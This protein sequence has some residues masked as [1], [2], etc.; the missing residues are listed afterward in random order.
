MSS[1]ITNKKAIVD[2]LWEW[3]A[4]QGDWSKLL[5]SKIVTTESPFQLLTEMRY[6]ITFYNPLIFTP[7]YP[8]L[9]LQS[10]VTHRLQNKYN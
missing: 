5:I 8:H 9:Q 10:L 6:S 1:T 3:T 4:N 2:F 7:A